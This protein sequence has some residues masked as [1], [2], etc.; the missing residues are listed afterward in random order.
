MHRPAVSALIVNYN[1]SSL[2][3]QCVASL[4]TERVAGGGGAEGVEIIV[5]DNASEARD[6]EM[7]S[8]LGVTVLFNEENR[9]YGAAIN[10][11]RARARA[12]LLLFSNPD[13][14][15]FP[16]SVARL[17][18]GLGDRARA[19]AVGPRIWWDRERRFLLPPSDAVTLA[20]YVWREVAAVR[21]ASFRIWERRWL[22]RAI[23]YWRSTAA[24]EQ[25][26]LSGACLLTSETAL[27]EI[28]GFDE[29]FHLY[30]EDADWCRRARA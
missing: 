20:G 17:V 26:M 23:G 1:T 13:T 11:A 21:P 6:R 29:R 18:D 3:R 22:R 14:Y 8:G 10:Q 16:G 7:L 4:R 12:D 28:G 27:G 19:G 24:V 25:P 2:T 9:G 5:V 15:Y 30:Y